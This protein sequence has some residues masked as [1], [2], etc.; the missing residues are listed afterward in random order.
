MKRTYY[1]IEQIINL[2]IAILSYISLNI[3]VLVYCLLNDKN[4]TLKKFGLR[5]WCT[6]KPYSYRV[7]HHGYSLMCC[8]GL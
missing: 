5:T 2:Y 8:P 3:F 6:N 1:I 4:K 7:I